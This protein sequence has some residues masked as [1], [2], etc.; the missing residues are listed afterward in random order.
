MCGG[1]PWFASS[2][3]S[4]KGVGFASPGISPVLWKRGRSSPL[5]GLSR[6]WLSSRQISLPAAQHPG[7]AQP[8]QEEHL[9]SLQRL[10]PRAGVARGSLLNVHS[11]PLSLV[12]LLTTATWSL[13]RAEVMLTLVETDFHVFRAV[14]S[15]LQCA[16]Q[17]LGTVIAAHWN[18]SRLY[19]HNCGALRSVFH[20][21]SPPLFVLFPLIR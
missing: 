12:V 11:S 6:T 3:P 17:L 18:L 19:K 21:P 8:P 4:E 14:I 16:Q 9:W 5:D 10:L 2:S 15:P 13:S 20:F 1:E 7:Q